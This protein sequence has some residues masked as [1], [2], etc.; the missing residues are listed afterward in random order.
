M[1]GNKH[2]PHLSGM[3]LQKFLCALMCIM[4]VS[5]ESQWGHPLLTPYLGR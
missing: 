4:Y 2:A 3:S 5:S 1:L